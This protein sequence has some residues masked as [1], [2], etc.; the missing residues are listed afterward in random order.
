MKA[1]EGLQDGFKFKLGNGMTSVWYEDWTGRGK[2]A[3]LLDFVHISDTNLKLRDLIL[4]D[5]WCFDNLYTVLPD[6]V[7]NL[8]MAVSPIIVDNMQDSWSWEGSNN[9]VYPVSDGYAWLKSHDGNLEP[10]IDWSWIWKLRISEKIKVF[11]L[12]CLHKAIPV[13]AKR[14]SCNKIY[15]APIIS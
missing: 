2:L 13:N 10:V 12:S 4:N 3:D 5:N 9:G 6:E 14:H 7:T 1:R 11:I 15:S 8:F